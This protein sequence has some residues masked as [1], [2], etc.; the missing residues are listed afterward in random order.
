MKA[1]DSKNIARKISPERPLH[2]QECIEKWGMDVAPGPNITAPSL[3]ISLRKWHESDAPALFA[4]AKDPAVG[5]ATGF[6]PHANAEESLRVIRGIL[7]KPEHYA[8]VA[9]EDGGLLGCIAL[10]P[11]RKGENVF[12]SQ[13]VVL[14]YW[15]GRPFWG[16][17]LMAEAIGLLCARAF[18]SGRFQ[19]T[20]IVAQTS[21]TN[22]RSRR[23][24]EKSG[25]RRA[26]LE[27]GDCR[28]ERPR[29]TPAP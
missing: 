2:L 9:A 28:Y 19:C 12:D 25:C 5:K 20:K 26:A 1:M 15:L 22:A 4:L 21:E 14:G 10:Y 11:P 3:R 13:E 18:G 27:N 8:V 7:S 6:P 17:G 23:L 16:Q 29:K 24:L